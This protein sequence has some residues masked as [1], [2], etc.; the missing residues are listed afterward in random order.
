MCIYVCVCIHIIYIQRSRGHPYGTAVRSHP[1]RRQRV[2][3]GNFIYTRI[4]MYMC[5]C[6]S[7]QIHKY[8]HIHMHIHTHTYI[9]IYIYIYI[10]LSLFRV[11]P[12]NDS[13]YTKKG[14]NSIQEGGALTQGQYSREGKPTGEH[15][16]TRGYGSMG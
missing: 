15:R 1:A 11:N 4:Y 5:V 7:I 13:L 9:Y 8:I 10:H 2:H 14:P 6:V 3:R 16:C 12:L